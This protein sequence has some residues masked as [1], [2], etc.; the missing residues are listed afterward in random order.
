MGNTDQQA[1]VNQAKNKRNNIIV[2]ALAVALIV[3]AGLFFMQRGQH[4]EIV[5]QL[6]A[7]KDSIQVEL[8]GM[9]VSYDSLRTENDTLNYNM[10]LAQTKVKDLLTEVQQIKKASYQQINR[11]KAEMGSL[12]KVMR[13]F[14]NQIDSLNRRNKILLAE[15]KEV[16]QENVKISQEK[17][18]LEKEKE[19]LVE[20]VAQ[21]AVLDAKYLKAEAITNRSKPTPKVKKVN[22]FRISFTLSKNVTARRGAKNVYI[23]ISR[24][25]ELIMLKSK[26]NVFKFEDLKIPYSAKREVE[27]EGEELPVNIFYAPEASELMKGEYTVDVF[28]DGNNI[29]TTKFI[30]K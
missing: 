19:K 12:R 15:N 6:N 30:L 1:G 13:S 24:P 16:K 22:K 21:A 28:A 4:S 17:K 8:S 7:E 29:G 14:V 3:V 25:D 2:I 5:K 18:Q 26:N 9:M 20:K 23:R 11:Y 10:Q 27:Y